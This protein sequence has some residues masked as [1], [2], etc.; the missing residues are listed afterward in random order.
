MLRRALSAAILIAALAGA[1]SAQE[2]AQVEPAAPR[3]TLHTTMGEVEITLDPIGAPKT[4]AHMLRLFKGKHYAGAS[5][6]RVEK[7]YL[8]Q[9]GDLDIDLNY[10]RP[11][12]G[13]VELETANNSHGRGKVALARD[14]APNSGRSSFYIDLAKNSHLNADPAAAPNTTGYAVFGRVTKGM[15]VVDAIARVELD[16]EKGPFPGKLPKT[17]I[18]IQRVTV[19]E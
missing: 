19:T 12:I 9:M 5:V 2:G 16:A 8:I 10:R 13:Y 14:D 15:D 11:P 1:A 17:P 7:D 3:V 18:V 4:S 6:F